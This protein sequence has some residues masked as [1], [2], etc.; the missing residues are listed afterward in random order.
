VAYH[1]IVS[2]GAKTFTLRTI[3]AKI[4]SIVKQALGWIT[5]FFTVVK[6]IL[7]CQGGVNPSCVGR[8]EQQ[9][10]NM[11]AAWMQLIYKSH[12]RLLRKPRDVM[13]RFNFTSTY[14][15]YTGC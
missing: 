1:T 4:H 15:M 10:I 9:K 11:V 12:I 5:L 3:A 8:V 14:F 6:I 7:I 2:L 13:C